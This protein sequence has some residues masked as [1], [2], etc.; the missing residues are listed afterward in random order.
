MEQ[1]GGESVQLHRYV[2][3]ELGKLNSVDGKHAEWVIRTAEKNG[4]G[5]K[6]IRELRE[7]EQE[8]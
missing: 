8:T 3:T 2:E 6:R 1:G 5:G 4:W 7:T